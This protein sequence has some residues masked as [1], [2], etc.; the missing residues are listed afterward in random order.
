MSGN[1]INSPEG[2][3]LHYHMGAIYPFAPNLNGQLANTTDPTPSWRA[4]SIPQLQESDAHSFLPFELE[5]EE[6]FVGRTWVGM[7]RISKHL[8][9]TPIRHAE[10]AAWGRALNSW[11][12]G[13]QQH[14]SLFANIEDGTLD[15]YFISNTQPWNMQYER[16]SINFLAVRGKDVGN[17]GVDSD[18]EAQISMEIPRRLGKPFLVET[19]ALL[20]HFSFGPQSKEMVKTD[21][22]ARYRDYAN[23][24]VC[25]ADN[26]KKAWPGWM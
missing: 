5:Q 18:D 14:Y 24:M 8:H 15:R 19:R 17:V 2:N 22:L 6:N 1:T 26:Q 4:S 10:Y 20:C 3:W 25:K 11:A 12:I 21:L 9:K 7:S 16:Y 13:A 23:E